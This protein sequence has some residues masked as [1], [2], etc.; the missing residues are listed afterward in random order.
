[1]QQEGVG[2]GVEGCRN[3][4]WAGWLPLSTDLHRHNQLAGGAQGLRLRCS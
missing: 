2:V 4:G 1:M 3:Q